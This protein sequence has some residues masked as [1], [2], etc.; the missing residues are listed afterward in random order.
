MI[1][2][3]PNAVETVACAA[4]RDHDGKV[5]MVPPPGRHHHIIRKMARAGCDLPITGEQGF[6]TDIGRFIDRAEA[7]RVATAAGQITKP[8]FQSNALFSED[9]W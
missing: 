3:N 7:V 6:V 2:A 5:W 1:A 4:I 9:L 8:K